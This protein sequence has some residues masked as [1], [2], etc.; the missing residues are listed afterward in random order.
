MYHIRG[1]VGQHNITIQNIQNALP[2][3]WFGGSPR[4]RQK[5]Y[6]GGG[7][8]REGRRERE[9]EEERQEIREEGSDDARSCDAHIPRQR[10]RNAD[11]ESIAV[12][13][14][15]LNFCGTVFLSA[16]NCTIGLIKLLDLVSQDVIFQ[17][18]PANVRELFDLAY[19]GTVSEYAT[20]RAGQ[21]RRRGRGGG[22]NQERSLARR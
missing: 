2:C 13:I 8:R 9:R 1:S 7:R 5:N 4:R 16:L 3:I 17:N 20:E 19:L 10:L 18:T 14:A 6:G 15:L 11:G 12:L 22:V 21:Q